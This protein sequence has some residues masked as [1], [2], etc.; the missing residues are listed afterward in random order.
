MLS[1]NYS[2]NCGKEVRAQHDLVDEVFAAIEAHG[3]GVAL[4]MLWTIPVL[5]FLVALMWTLG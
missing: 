2:S 3:S 5:G 4:A 1:S